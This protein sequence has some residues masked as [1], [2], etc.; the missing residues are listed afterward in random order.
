MPVGRTLAVSLLGL[1]GTLVEIEADVSSNLPNFILVG[2]PDASLSEAKDRVRSACSNSGLALPAKRITVNLSPASVPKFG[3]AFDVGIAIA[4]LVAAGVCD[5]HSIARTAHVGELALDGSLRP[6]RGVLPMVMAAKSAGAKRI[7]V[8]EAN[9]V[10]AELAGDI[11]VVSA[12]HLAELAG[13]HGAK[14]DLSKL[15]ALRS[16]DASASSVRFK[17]SE[18]RVTV[19]DMADVLG[20]PDIV[21]ALLVAAV[22]AHHVLMVGPPG[23]GKTMLAE[24]LPTILPDLALDDALEVSAV[25]SIAGFGISNFADL[26]V[27]PPFESPHHSASSTSIVGGGTGLPRP[28]AISLAHR[29]VLFLDEAPEFATPVLEALRQP[30]ESGTVQI[31]RAAGVARFPAKFQLVLAANPCPCGMLSVKNN[32]CVCSAQSRTRYAAKLSGPL[33]DRIDLRLN[34]RPVTQVGAGLSSGL[35][36]SSAQLRDA[37]AEARVRSVRRLLGTG[38]SLNSQVGSSYFRR[39]LKLVAG[40]S[41]DIDEALRKRTL[42]M[43]GYDRCLRLALSCADLAGRDLPNRDDVMRALFL[44]GSDTPLAEA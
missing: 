2:L 29:G 34:V 23:A 19:P 13:I 44:R 3:S 12:G 33:L 7:V 21:D 38:Y 42:S 32:R 8:P 26:R 41:R 27:R 20:Q 39:E 17:S 5:A 16:P 37:V 36:H 1:A 10:E 6:V 28:G 11:E 14:V 15:A 43:R 4:I 40:A 9:R 25:Q 22:G 30:L 18:T 24:R 35:G 31:H